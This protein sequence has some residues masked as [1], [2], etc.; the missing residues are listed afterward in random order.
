VYVWPVPKLDGRMPK[1]SSGYRTASRPN[2]VGVDIMYWRLPEDGGEIGKFN[3]PTHSRK[4]FMPHGKPAVSFGPGVVTKSKEIGTGGYVAIEHPGGWTTQYMHLRDRRVK[5]G[6]KVKLGTPI[7]EVHYNPYKG[8][9]Q[10]IHLHFQTRKNG[11]LVDPEPVLKKLKAIDDPWDFP[12][13]NL[14]LVAVVSYGAYKL[15]K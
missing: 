10:L 11:E 7:G 5:V 9:H 3:Y 4:H 15:L 13:G 6:D 1:I 2:H 8:G 14:I 12:W